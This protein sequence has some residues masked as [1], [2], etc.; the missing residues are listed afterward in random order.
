MSEISEERVLEIISNKYIPYF[1]R[2]PIYRGFVDRY[3]IDKIWFEE[4]SLFFAI[5][6]HI[7]TDS[8][9][10]IGML[11]REEKVT[12]EM[13]LRAM[14]EVGYESMIAKRHATDIAVDNLMAAFDL[15][16]TPL[17]DVVRWLGRKLERLA[18]RFLGSSWLR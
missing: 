16:L 2:Q 18:G 7:G 12:S 1:V 3:E 17:Y 11:V 8:Y 14:D 4:P 13:L 15:A 6:D 9:V 5:A 10:K